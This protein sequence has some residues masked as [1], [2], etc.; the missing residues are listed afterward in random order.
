MNRNKK[1]TI[2]VCVLLTTLNIVACGQVKEDEIISKDKSVTGQQESSVQV[3]ENINS[4]TKISVNDS[5]YSSATDISRTEV[6]DFAAYVKQSF[7]EHDWLAISSEISYPITISGTTYSDSAAFLDASNNFDNNLNEKFFSYLEEEDCVEMFVN[8]QGIML[9]ETGQI[10]IADVLDDK[11]SSHG[12]MILAINDLLKEEEQ[13][14]FLKEYTPADVTGEDQTVDFDTSGLPDAY[15]AAI[16]EYCRT[17]MFPDGQDGGDIPGKI[18]YAVYDVDGDGKEE[19]ILKNQDTITAGMTERVYAYEDGVFREEFSGFPAL[20]YYDNGLIHAEWS[21]NQGKAGDRL[22]PYTL[23]QYQPDNDSYIML[24]AVDA[25]DKELADF[26]SDWGAFPDDI[27]ADGDGYIYFLLPSDWEG[28]YSRADIVDGSDYENWRK[29]YLAG[30]ET[31]EIPYQE[32]EV[33][34]VLPDAAG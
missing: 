3:V 18:S 24:E 27:D 26:I 1:I 11:S 14:I 7:M 32:L 17:G 2:L 33:E 16:Q 30:A 13:E 22:W 29:H 21:H 12:L 9:G 23:Y 20:T 5:Y 15:N 10:W 8:S 19:L 6:E 4:E 25:W 28:Q 31:L 34:T